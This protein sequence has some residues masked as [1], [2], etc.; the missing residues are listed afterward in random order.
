M[1]ALI[2]LTCLGLLWLI[3]SRRWRRRVVGPAILLSLVYLIG[4]SSWMVSLATQGMLWFLPTDTGESADVIVVLGR[5]EALRARRLELVEQLWH[6]KRAPKIFV[7]GMSDA[8]PMVEYLKESGIPAASLS[9]EN[10]SQSTQENALFT[11]AL[12]YPQG[13]RKILLLT[14]PPHLL[15]AFLLFRS[16]GFTVIPHPSPVPLQWSSRDQ[17]RLV[18]REYLGLV[19]Y[20][21]IGYFRQRTEAE[22]N[23]PPAEVTETISSWNC[24]IQ[25]A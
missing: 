5:G 13:I 2:F 1:E 18:L 17:A 25:G 15:R 3:S 19:H 6:A 20:A 12:L 24:K 23:Q 22:L 16:S 4:T 7:S 9:G 8:H 21:A 14:D 11:A 10:C